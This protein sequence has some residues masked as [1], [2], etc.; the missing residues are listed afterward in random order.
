MAAVSFIAVPLAAV[1]MFTIVV[2]VLVIVQIFLFII[3]IMEVSFRCVFMVKRAVIVIVLVVSISITI[4][5]VITIV[6]TIISTIIGFVR[7]FDAFSMIQIK[8]K[9]FHGLLSDSQISL[10]VM[11]G[12]HLQNQVAVGSEGVFRVEGACILLEASRCLVPLA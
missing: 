8:A 9:A 7:W 6:V 11:F 5:M 1:M 3:L 2:A 10:L 4:M 12:L